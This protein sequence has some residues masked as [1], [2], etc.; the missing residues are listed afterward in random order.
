MS[1]VSG[2]DGFKEWEPVCND[3]GPLPGR[4]SLFLAVENQCHTDAICVDGCLPVVTGTELIDCLIKQVGDFRLAASKLELEN[5][6]L[7]VDFNFHAASAMCV[8]DF[9]LGNHCCANQKNLHIGSATGFVFDWVAVIVNGR[10]DG[11]EVVDDGFEGAFFH[12]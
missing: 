6:M 10:H 2:R 11:V 5:P 4:E 8:V 7:S 9:H 12:R 3:L 1:V